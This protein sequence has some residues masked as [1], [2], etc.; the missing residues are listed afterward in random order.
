MP[1]T[2]YLERCDCI[3]LLDRLICE[4][5]GAADAI[6][7]P[8]VEPD[9]DVRGFQKAPIQLAN[10]M[11][12]QG[13]VHEDG[14]AKWADYADYIVNHERKPSI[15]PLSCFRGE[16]GS[17][18]G[19]GA[20]NPGQIDAYI[21]NGGFH[22]HHVPGKA[23]YYKPW[24]SAYQDWAVD[25]GLYD[26]PQPYLFELYSETMR[27]F[28]RAAEGHGERQP[29]EHLSER[30]KDIMRPLPFWYAPFED[31]HVDTE[32]F[33]IHALTQRPMAMYHS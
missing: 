12:L 23:A 13:F 20:V 8:V 1:D 16:D 29:A 9:R 14:S 6:R 26:A 11:K 31:A 17:Q 32:E 30:L 15:G 21:A 25:L 5:D 33:P 7:W 18:T 22:V 27:K 24:N 4:A 3:S 2:T 10:R 19:R 28:Q